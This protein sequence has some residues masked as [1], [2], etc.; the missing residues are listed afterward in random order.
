MILNSGYVLI[1][2]SFMHRRL[3]PTEKWRWYLEDVGQPL[4]VALLVAGA[5]R[6][7]LPLPVDDLP[8]AAC[9]AAISG[10]VLAATAA[11]TPVTRKWF[12]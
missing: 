11:A 4:A 8:L 9:I 3:L 10:V 6:M 12:Q 5:F 1:S 7:S 2:I